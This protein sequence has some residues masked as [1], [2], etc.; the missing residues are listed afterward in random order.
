MHYDTTGNYDPV[1]LT[2]VSIQVAIRNA[3]L[4]QIVIF[5]C[6]NLMMKN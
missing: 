2:A 4:E 5:P 1:S 6:E 3:S